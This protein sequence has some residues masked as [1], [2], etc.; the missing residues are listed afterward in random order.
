MGRERLEG[1]PLSGGLARGPAVVLDRSRELTRFPLRADQVASEKVRFRLAVEAIQKDLGKTRNRIGELFGEDIAGIFEAHRLILTDPAF[2]G[3]VERQIGEQRVNAEWAVQEVSDDL[4]DR[5]AQIEDEHLRERGQDLRDVTRYLLRALLGQQEHHEITELREDVVVVAEDLTPDETLRYGRQNVAAFLVQSGGQNSHSAI[6][7]RAL[8]VPM[9][10][11]VQPSAETVRDEAPVLVDGDR[12]VVIFRPDESDFAWYEREERNRRQRESAHQETEAEDLLTAD[13][14]QVVVQ[15]NVE[16]LEEL[17][18]VRKWGS[19]GIGLYR[20]EFLYLERSPD[21]PTEDEHYHTFRALLEG[22]APHAVVIRTFD[23]GGRKLA[24]RVARIEEE[25]PSLGL[26]GIRLTLAR[27]E[28]FRTQLR[29]LY[30]VGAEGPLQVLLPMVSNLD[31][32]R[33]FK[34]LAADVCDEL[35]AE[36]VRHARDLPLG[37]MIEVPS[38]ALIA[39]RLCEEVDFMSLGTNDLIQYCLAVDRGNELVADWYQPLHP[40]LLRLVHRVASEGARSG[41]PVTLC[42]EMGS[43]PEWIELLLGLGLRRVS[44]APRATADVR[45]AVRQVDL[46]RAEELASACLDAGSSEDVTRL[47]A[48]RAST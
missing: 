12:G 13:G 9:V 6:V 10:A 2:S 48:R 21:L 47:L 41:T 31:E 3:A 32:V 27:Q 46:A 34:A 4:T 14:V 1:R 5:F 38:A 11:G 44:V 28:I 19:E 36:G 16:L 37:V 33:R 23:L 7:A 15:A 35:E 43:R 40:A 8:S 22:A 18:D 25:N 45:R 26:R 24:R 20:S 17:D 29:A 39:D 42:G 30:R